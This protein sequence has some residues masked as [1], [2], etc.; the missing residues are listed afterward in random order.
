MTSRR[1]VAVDVLCALLVIPVWTF[2]GAVAAIVCALVLGLL[3][4]LV[5]H[6]GSA[7]PLR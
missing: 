2:Y 4:R 7:G 1:G 3:L 5:V 6:N